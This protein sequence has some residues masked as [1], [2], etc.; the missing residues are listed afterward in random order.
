MLPSIRTVCLTIRCA[1]TFVKKSTSSCA[2]PGHRVMWWMPFTSVFMRPPDLGRYDRRASDR[3]AYCLRP[4]APPAPRLEIPA[5][6]EL[7]EPRLHDGHRPL[8]RRAERVVLHDDCVR[9]EPVEQ[10]DVEIES[11]PPA[12]RHH[13]G[14]PQVDFVEPIAPHV[15]RLHQPERCRSGGEIPAQRSC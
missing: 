13:L 5:G 2:P 9:I 15:I 4:E 12:R 6:A 7:H 3:I 10:I 8:P 11:A 14:E 1:N